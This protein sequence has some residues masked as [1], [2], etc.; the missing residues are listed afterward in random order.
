MVTGRPPYSIV[1]EKGTTFYLSILTESVLLDDG[2]DA[3]A[4]NS[5]TFASV[6][7]QYFV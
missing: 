6:L 4:K 5:G 7:N 1:G 2:E 3:K